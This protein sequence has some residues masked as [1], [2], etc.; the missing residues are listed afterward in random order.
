MNPNDSCCVPKQS[1]LN[2]MSDNTSTTGGDVAK[3]TTTYKPGSYN[4]PEGGVVKIV[5]LPERLAPSDTE[6]V[7]QVIGREGCYFVKITERSG[8]DYLW[9]DREG[10]TVELWVTDEERQKKALRLA[11]RMIVTR[12][13]QVVD[14][15][16]DDGKHVSENMHTW[17]SEQAR[18]QRF[19][20]LP[21]WVHSKYEDLAVDSEEEE[22]VFPPTELKAFDEHADD[23]DCGDYHEEP[24]VEF[25][26]PP[27]AVYP[28]PT[29]YPHGVPPPLDTYQRHGWMEPRP[30]LPPHP[31]QFYPSPYYGVGYVPVPFHQA[32]YVPPPP[33]PWYGEQYGGGYGPAYAPGPRQYPGGRYAGRN[34]RTSHY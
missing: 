24:P 14:Q 16:L 13:V 17:V 19:K 1:T 5:S 30:I 10:N 23:C 4:P 29:G 20:P 34:Y 2:K 25:S 18:E 11:T 27:T 26:E 31:A 33:Q 7:K 12:F 32:P 21:D 9:H 3:K 8:I 22:A 28:P 6:V 15:R